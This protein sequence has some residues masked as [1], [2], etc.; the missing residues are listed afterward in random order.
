VPTAA[1]II[2]AIRLAR[3]RA[4]PAVVAARTVAG[5]LARA[6]QRRRGTLLAER[7]AQAESG[8]SAFLRG[9][10]LSGLVASVVLILN[11]QYLL[12]NPLWLTWL[13]L[14]CASLL[15]VLGSLLLG[16]LLGARGRLRR[17]LERRAVQRRPHALLAGT[18]W[19]VAGGVLLQVLGVLWLA[20]G[21]Y[22]VALTVR[23]LTVGS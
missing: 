21:A 12:G 6:E 15:F 18:S 19:R 13:R 5:E 4:Q 11:V 7:Q 16:D 1:T 10:F 23:L 14:A 9:L 17:E 3:N 22:E 2:Q 20:G 8:G